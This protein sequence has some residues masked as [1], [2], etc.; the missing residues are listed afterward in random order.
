AD[1]SSFRRLVRLY[2]GDMAQGGSSRKV[3]NSLLAA[4]AAAVLAVYAAG[5]ERTR[6]AAEQ[7][8]AQSAVRRP[9]ARA[10]AVVVPPAPAAQPKPLEAQPQEP[11]EA[12]REVAVLAHPSE[13]APVIA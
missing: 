4:G 10:A 7:L 13:P 8:E 6:P 5:Y 3:A 2:S 1:K 12:P 11:R 9:V